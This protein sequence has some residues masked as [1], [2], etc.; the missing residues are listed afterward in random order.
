MK[1]LALT[2][3][4]GRKVL[5]VR[6][7]WQTIDHV[8]AIELMIVIFLMLFKLYVNACFIREKDDLLKMKKTIKSEESKTKMM[9]IRLEKIKNR[10]KLKELSKTLNMEENIDV[11]II[12]K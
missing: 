3:K 11:I 2:F 10:E 8:L 6:D 12:K 9:K 5:K 4:E 7:W 1:E